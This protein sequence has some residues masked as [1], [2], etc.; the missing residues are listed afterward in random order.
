M[1]SRIALTG[2][3]NSNVWPTIRIRS[4]D[5]AAAISASASTTLAVIGFS[6]NVCLPALIA[7]SASLKC[8][9]IGVAMT[10]ASTSESL[11]MSS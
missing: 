6:T 9:R 1:M 4:R 7:A 2:E 5:S 10:T 11:S 3:L 8:V